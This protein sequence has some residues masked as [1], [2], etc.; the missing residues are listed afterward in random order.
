MSGLI[1][2]ASAIL[3]TAERRLEASSQNVANA[4][5][6]GFK[7]QVS[8]TAALD[9]TDGERRGPAPLATL[10]DFT[11]GRLSETGRPLDLA[12]YGPGLFQLRDGDQ[13]VYSRG[14]SF[15]RN[16]DGLLGDAAGRVLQQAGGGDL[17]LKGEAP[18]ILEDGTV[19]EDG[20]PTA[21]LALYEA[22]KLSAL[23]ALGGSTFAADPV[24]LDEAAASQVRQGFLENSNVVMSDEMIAMMAAVRQAESGGRLV[25]FYDELI[26]QAI[27]TFSRSG[28]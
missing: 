24:A 27:T 22:G 14:G 4:S 21:R 6:T 16:A 17:E 2:S 23:T 19:L 9:G 1:D 28:K 20:L 15:T 12:I 5:T 8:F 10:A 18:A 3:S 13:L 11:Q 25:Q 26:G 7:R